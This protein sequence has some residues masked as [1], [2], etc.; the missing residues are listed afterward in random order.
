MFLF[1][2][3]NKKPSKVSEL[4]QVY[5]LTLGRV[6]VFV[7]TKIKGRPL[8]SRTCSLCR[9]QSFAQCVAHCRCLIIVHG[10]KINW[11]KSAVQMILVLNEPFPPCHEEYWTHYVSNTV[12]SLLPGTV[13]IHSLSNY[14][15][16]GKAVDTGEYIDIKN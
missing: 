14:Y 1:L 11:R 12:W 4:G 10:I 13:F 3:G 15:A 9:P 8:S 6:F 5:D 7:F 2:M 16:P